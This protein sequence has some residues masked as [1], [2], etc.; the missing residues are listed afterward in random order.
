VPQVQLDDLPVARVQPGDR[1]LDKLAQLAPPGAGAGL[2]VRG[3]VGHLPGL[4]QCCR[5]VAGPQPA[6][7]LVAS[8][9]VQPWP[10]PVRLAQARQPGRGDEVGVLHGIG[11]VG[12]LGEQ[13]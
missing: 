8:H 4:F 2:D 12:R 10:E 1:R 5:P 7:A 3:C 13:Q 11:G 6:V 9:R